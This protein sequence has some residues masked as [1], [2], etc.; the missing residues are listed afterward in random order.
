[1]SLSSGVRPGIVVEEDGSLSFWACFSQ[2]LLQPIELLAVVGSSDGGVLRQQLKH[3]DAFRIP[4]DREHDLF[5][6]QLL[7]GFSFGR[8][9]GVHPLTFSSNVGIEGPLFVACHH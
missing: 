1:M 2:F 7:T 4:E 5:G 8:C 3:D 6:V 9:S